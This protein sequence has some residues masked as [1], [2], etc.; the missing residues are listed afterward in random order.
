MGTM[1]RHNTQNGQNC[2]DNRSPFKST[3]HKGNI[4]PW[5]MIIT[6]IARRRA[7]RRCFRI[8]TPSDIRPTH[9]IIMPRHR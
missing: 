5:S 8:G 3:G 2:C 4:L 1:A 9:H 6:R 7:R